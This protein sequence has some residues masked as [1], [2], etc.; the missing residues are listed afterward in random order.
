VYNLN[1]EK[2]LLDFG[3]MKYQILLTD[4]KGGHKMATT[5]IVFSLSFI[6]F[7][8]FSIGVIRLIKRRTK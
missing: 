3:W 1:G 7:Y 6:A 5:I 8:C 2:I 4:K